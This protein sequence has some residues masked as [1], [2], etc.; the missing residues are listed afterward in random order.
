MNDS[1]VK[2]DAAFVR[3]IC[4]LGIETIE[5]ERE[6]IKNAYV[7]KCMTRSFTNWFPAK[8]REAALAHVSL[9]DNGWSL[10]KWLTCGRLVNLLAAATVH[11][12][13]GKIYLSSEDAQLINRF[14][15]DY[16]G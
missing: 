8:S 2:V 3:R 5:K 10:H 9:W 15:P 6:A 11:T 4:E 16:T 1:Y 7:K 13:D 14:D 12:S